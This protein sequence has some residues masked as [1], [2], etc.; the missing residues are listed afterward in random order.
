MRSW[1]YTSRRAPRDRYTARE[2]HV[3]HIHRAHTSKP[4]NRCKMNTML[5]Y[6]TTRILEAMQTFQPTLQPLYGRPVSLNDNV[7]WGPAK[8]FQGETSYLEHSQSILPRFW[9]LCSLLRVRSYTILVQKAQSPTP[10]FL[11]MMRTMDQQG[12]WGNALPRSPQQAP[13][14]LSLTTSLPRLSRVSRHFPA[15]GSESIETLDKNNAEECGIAG[16]NRERTQQ[17]GT[18]GWGSYQCE[19]YPLPSSY[20]LLAA[21]PHYCGAPCPQIP[22]IPQI[23]PKLPRRNIGIKSQWRREETGDILV[24]RRL[25]DQLFPRANRFFYIISVKIQPAVWLYPSY[26]SRHSPR[27]QEHWD[28]Q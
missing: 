1:S 9:C 26:P 8:S 22:R 17:L 10:L 23:A 24:E 19:D 7:N 2:S 11:S 14:A 15:L 27:F 20:L 12:Q 21:C 5:L 18:N 3:H 16:T 6:P 4:S 28:F 13:H 25:M